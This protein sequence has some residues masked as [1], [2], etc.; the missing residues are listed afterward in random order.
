M[1][2]NECSTS[3]VPTIRHDIRINPKCHID[4]YDPNNPLLPVA[5]Q[6]TQIVWKATTELGCARVFCPGGS[7][8]IPGNDV[9]P[10]SFTL[11]VGRR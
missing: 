6:F 1:W 11:T 9:R 4:S 2:A 7:L 3:I 8:P 5:W 10:N